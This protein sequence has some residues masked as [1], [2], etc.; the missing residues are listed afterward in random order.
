MNFYSKKNDKELKEYEDL[1]GLSIK[2]LNFG[3]WFVES[4]IFFQKF[5]LG[6]LFL[7]AIFSNFYGWG[8]FLFYFVSGINEDKNMIYQMLKTKSI[9]KEYTRSREPYDIDY[10]FIKA[11]KSTQSDKYD[12][13]AKIK[14]PNQDHYVNFKYCF[15]SGEIEISC[16][17]GFVL[18][19]EEKFLLSLNKDFNSKISSI[20]FLLKDVSFT[21]LNKHV[22][23]DWEEYKKNHLDFI[24]ENIKF[25]P[26]KLSEEEKIEVLNFDIRN[27][28]AFNFWE[29]SINIVFYNGNSI[30]GVDQHIIDNFMSAS[31]KNISKNYVDYFNYVNNVDIY[32]NINT[33]NED[34]YMQYEG[35]FGSK[36]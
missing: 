7:I 19:E 33:I 26:S 28:T 29:V 15:Y 36:K 6:L 25:E 9:T 2:K 30:I 31:T 35:G 34:I 18:P 13:F 27:N 8:H 21:R 16:E 1:E 23:P 5:F 3:L 17:S 14:N 4:K 24:I 11:T 10:S 20:K 12:L 22:Y 32:L